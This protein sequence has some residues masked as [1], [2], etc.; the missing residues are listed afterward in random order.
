M[1]NFERKY[2]RLKQQL[3]GGF[4]GLGGVFIAGTLWY[5]LIENW[6]WAEAAYMTT[7]T[8]STVGFGE[9]RPL[10]DRSR[11]FTVAL[12]FMGIFVIGYIANRFTEAMIGGYFREGLRRRQRRRSIEMLKH[13]YI[14]CGYGRTGSQIA[15]EFQAEHVPFIVIDSQSEALDNARLRGYTVIQG[16]ATHDD[17]LLAAGI[18][19]ADCL[20]AALQSDAENLYTILSAKTLNP[21]IRAIARANSEEAITKLERAGAD[22]VV[23]PYITGGRRL[24]AAALRP[25]AIDFVDGIITGTNRS[26]YL[27]EFFLDEEHCPHI[28]KTLQETNLRSH[29]GALVLAIRRQ[30]GTLIGGPTGETLLYSGDLLICMGTA[31]QLRALNKI[32]GTLRGY[33]SSPIP[34][35]KRSRRRI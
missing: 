32:L 7:I 29:S 14:L 13:H 26:L 22:A 3:L 4:A 16:D 8:L 18:D 5:S 28:G 33:W 35:K 30:D 31:D 20:V 10:S 11:I 17:C 19:R 12:I 6:S 24:A 23:S 21:R 15:L 27:D 2:Q 34:E 9:I 25:S 1:Y